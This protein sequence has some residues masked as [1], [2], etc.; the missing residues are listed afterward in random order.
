MKQ[1]EEK[2]EKKN[3]RRIIINSCVTATGQGEVTS[4]LDA[5]EA[6]WKTE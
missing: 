6:D 2:G 3:H 4:A 5:D 1:V